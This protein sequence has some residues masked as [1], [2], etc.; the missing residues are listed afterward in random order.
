MAINSPLN[1]GTIA[2]QRRPN[3]EKAQNFISG[4][5]P[6]GSSVFTAAANNIVGFTRGAGISPR[7]PNLGSIIQALSSNIL[8]NV[9]G[10]IQNINQNVTQIVGDRLNQLQSDYQQRVDTFDSNTPNKL[11]QT[12][13]GLYDKAIGYI[14]FL[15]DRRNIKLLGDNLKALQDNFTESFDVAKR[16][17]KTIINIVNQL[18]S[19]PKVS[20]SGGSGLN[21]DVNV[22]GG[23]LK[24]NA[25]RGMSRM[26]RRPGLMLGSAAL[27]GAGAGAIA[28]SALSGPGPVKEP[29]QVSG[30]DMTEGLLVRF[31]EVLDRFSQALT[32]LTGTGQQ[33]TKSSGGGGGTTIPSTDGG[34]VA[35]SSSLMNTSVEPGVETAGLKSNWTYVAEDILKSGKIDSKKLSD[36][37]AMGAMLAIGQME[38]DFAPG[39][40]YSGLG[41]LNNNM[42]GFLQLNRKYHKVQGKDEYLNYVIPKFTGEDKSFTGGSRFNPLKFAEGLR[43]AE[44]GWDV[45]QAA[46]AAGFTVDDFDPLDTP[47]ESNRLTPDQVR[48]IKQMVFGNLNPNALPQKPQAKAETAVEKLGNVVPATTQSTTRQQLSKQV[49]QPPA[50]QKTSTVNVLPM[51]GGTGQSGGSPQSQTTSSGSLSG[52]KIPFLYASNDDNFLTL[53]SKMVYSIVDA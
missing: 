6:L 10:A 8:N 42:Q 16:I 27:L 33:P 43:N 2:S 26:M 46:V 22:P 9:Q 39:E 21:L 19:L 50:T 35:P 30:S 40:M 3:P 23:R 17:R 53:Y 12:F 25:P 28:T 41:G 36:R 15:G 4:G 24:K 34:P 14:K 13:L 44:T 32:N 20:G 5:S 49:A 29:E 1:P 45:A 31:N 47:G 7:Q 48:V 11:L 18:S 52:N 37:A 38:S 51:G